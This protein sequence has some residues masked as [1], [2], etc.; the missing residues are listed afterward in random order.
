MTCPQ[1]HLVHAFHDGELDA[2]ASA[3]VRGHV[4][5]CPAC[6]AE[7]A[8]LE[9]LA[10]Q[11]REAAPVAVPLELMSAVHR[12]INR[13]AD[14]GVLRLARWLTA[15][16]AV[17]ALASLGWLLAGQGTSAGA[18]G[19]ANANWQNSAALAVGHLPQPRDIAEYQVANWFVRNLSPDAAA[20]Q[21]HPSASQPDLLP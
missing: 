5:Q 13:L 14:P 9:Q 17:M 21:A 10:Q 16:A 11:V 8:W 19:A 15:A 6:A 4:R 2:Q 20:S 12:R 3:A 1:T 18:T 7:L